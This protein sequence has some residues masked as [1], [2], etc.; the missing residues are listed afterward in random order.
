M[1]K[2]VSCALVV[3]LAA[4][5]CSRAAKQARQGHIVVAITMDWEGAYL[6]PEGLDAVDAVRA[7]LGPD[8]PVTHF[9]CAAY[10]T[11]AAPDPEILATLTQSVRAGDELAVHLHAW[12]SLAVAAAI[13]PKLAPSFLT[14]TDKLLEFEDG[15][16]GFDTDLDAYT[17]P[18]LRALLRTSRKLLE[19]TARPVSKAFRAG[20]YLGTPKVLQA[21]RDE[22]YTIDSSAIDH[23]QLDE[24]QDDVLPRRVGEIWPKVDTSSQPWRVPLRGGELIEMPLAAVA[25]YATAAEMT[26]IFDAAGKQL[27]AAPARDVFVVLGLHQETAGDFGAHVREAVAAARARA[28]LAPHLVFTTVEHAASLARAGG[29]SP[30]SR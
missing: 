27:A 13:Q 21:I 7:A 5:G 12:R 15:D 17:V 16:V 19:Q 20:G 25:D 22:G 18:E 24:R 30:S 23:R 4:A 28:D 29:L 3:A 8:V 10:F 2:I 1:T 11:K 6:S 14:G 26:A 9:V